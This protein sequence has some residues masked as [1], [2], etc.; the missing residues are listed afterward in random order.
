M[1]QI[2]CM[3]KHTP[4][5]SEKC[6]ESIKGRI[7]DIYADYHQNYGAPK[8]TKKL[9][10]EGEHIAEQTVGDY[11]RQMGLR[12]QWMNSL[13]PMHRILSEC[14]ISHTAGQ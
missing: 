6:R 9:L 1:F 8:I 11:M 5:E 4:S 14:L 2:L 12:A 7:R 10:A 3:E 13:I